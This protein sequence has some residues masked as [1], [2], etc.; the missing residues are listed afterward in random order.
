MSWLFLFLFNVLLKSHYLHMIL[1]LIYTLNLIIEIFLYG[2]FKKKLRRASESH[3]TPEPQIFWQKE[4]NPFLNCLFSKGLKA[5]FQKIFRKISD[6]LQEKLGSE[7]ETLAVNIKLC[8]KSN[9]KWP[10]STCVCEPEASYRTESTTS[11]IAARIRG[12]FPFKIENWKL[13]IVFD[14]QFS[15]LF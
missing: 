13:K 6:D 11:S 2:L 12:L 10:L 9:S 5:R 8:I 4:P 7:L 3:R 1:L 14:S 15:I